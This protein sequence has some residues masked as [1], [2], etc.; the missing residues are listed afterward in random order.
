MCQ[1]EMS[2][3][4]NRVWTRL[5]V[6]AP[7]SPNR[8]RTLQHYTISVLSGLAAVKM[9]EGPTARFRVDE[10]A[11]L[12]DTLIRELGSASQGASEKRGLEEG[13]EWPD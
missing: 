9:M 3:A 1:M 10:L 11:L 12:K 8:S 2:R 7:L 13:D 4:W 6:D 5:F